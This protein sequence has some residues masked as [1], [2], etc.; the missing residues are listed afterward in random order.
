MPELCCL[1]KNKKLNNAAKNLSFTRFWKPSGGISHTKIHF[2]RDEITKFELLRN[3]VI[4]STKRG[5]NIVF[6]N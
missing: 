5:K 6:G 2:F 3:E 4:V 1:V